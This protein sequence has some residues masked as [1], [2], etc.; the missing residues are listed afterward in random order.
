MRRGLQVDAILE[1][2]TQLMRLTLHGCLK[3]TR[4]ARA[5]V[6]E[7]WDEQAAQRRGEL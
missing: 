2:C 7:A 1:H 5:R 3:I 4:R 6:Q